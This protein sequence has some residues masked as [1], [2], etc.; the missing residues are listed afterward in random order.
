MPGNLRRR[1]AM[2]LIP[3]LALSG[4]AAAAGAC[5]HGPSAAD[6][7]HDPDHRGHGAH[8]M[9]DQVDSGSPVGVGCDCGCACAGNCSHACQS[10][11]LTNPP[12]FQFRTIAAV[13]TSGTPGVLPDI[14][15]HP[16]FKPPI[17]FL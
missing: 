15:T 5:G 3:L 1:I 7:M 16:P 6:A 8:V 17:S 4:G 14:S 10:T 13:V 12:L 11:T 2:L 9:P